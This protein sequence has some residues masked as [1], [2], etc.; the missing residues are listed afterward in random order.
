M[1]IS[2]APFDVG[3]T[4]HVSWLSDTALALAPS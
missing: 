4:A 3:D 2:E 1:E